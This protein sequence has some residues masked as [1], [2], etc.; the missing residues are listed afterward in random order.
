MLKTFVSILISELLEL[1]SRR[2]Q[3]YFR[4]KRLAKENN[5]EAKRIVEEKD[6]VKRSERMRD[7]L[8]S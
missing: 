7:F 2:L 5:E 1:A 3:E 6:P 4:L 8:S